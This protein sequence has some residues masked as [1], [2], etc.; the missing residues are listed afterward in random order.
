MNDTMSTTKETKL[1]D[2]NHSTE[3]PRNNE[4]S[5]MNAVCAI[6][7]SIVSKSKSVLS[8][9]T[10]EIWKEV[11]RFEGLYEV[12]SLGRIR[13]LAGSTWGRNKLKLH[14]VLKDHPNSRNY[15]TISLYDRQGRKRTYFTHQIVAQAFLGDNSCCFACGN[16]FEVNHKDRDKKNNRLDNLEYVT[17]KENM[18]YYHDDGVSPSLSPNF[19]TDLIKAS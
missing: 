5:Q 4:Q 11:K 3:L 6:T 16:K 2:E 17:H 12:S 14:R 13:R 19:V 7:G 10:I 9:D 1:W 8:P 18:D 15:R